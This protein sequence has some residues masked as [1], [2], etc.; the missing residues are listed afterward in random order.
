MVTVAGS[1]SA[2][3][4]NVG[5][6]EDNIVFKMN[7]DAEGP[8][9]VYSLNDAGEWEPLFSQVQ[10]YPIGGRW[11]C[12]IDRRWVGFS[13]SYGSQTDNYSQSNGTG[14]EPTLAWS[15]FG[16]FLRQ[17]ATAREI[18]G[19][20]RSSSAEVTGYDVRV[21]FQTGNLSSGNWDSNGETTRDLLYSANNVSFVDT[22]WLEVSW[23]LGNFV[24]PSD[25]VILV[26]IRP[27][28][29][30]T[31]VRYIYGPLSLEYELA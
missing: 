26:H 14:A 21:Y 6:P 15:N 27:V 17:G 28:G 31:A 12:N 8:R 22:N 30:I 18:K 1:L 24:A 23:P 10:A 5:T 29:T 4:K 2:V 7:T 19:M 9:G 13:T 16:P 11:Y 25:G 3:P 20:F